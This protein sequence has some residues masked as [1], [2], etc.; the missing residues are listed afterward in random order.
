MATT[1]SGLLSYVLLYW[2]KYRTY[3][4]LSRDIR[5][6]RL[7]YATALENGILGT[8]QKFG[9]EVCE[10]GETGCQKDL[11]KNPSYQGFPG[12]QDSSPSRKLM[13]ISLILM[14]SSVCC[15]GGPM[16][17]WAGTF[18]WYTESPTKNTE[19]RMDCP[20][21]GVWYRQGCRRGYALC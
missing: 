11:V 13:G 1:T 2:I 6:E 21:G 5:I 8:A 4:L 10:K 9:L 20:G 14:G 18:K 17:P 3:V 19:T 16:G 7:A 12:C 15:A